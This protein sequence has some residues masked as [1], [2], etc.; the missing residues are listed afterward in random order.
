MNVAAALRLIR[1][2]FPWFAG[3]AF[4]SSVGAELILDA[5]GALGAPVLF[6]FL[7]VALCQIALL[8]R[9]LRAC[10][11]LALEKGRPLGA[12]A[13]SVLPLALLFALAA[14][15]GWA[16]QSAASPLPGTEEGLLCLAADGAIGFAFLVLGALACLWG[17]DRDKLTPQARCCME[18]VSPRMVSGKSWLR[19]L[20]I[21]SCNPLDC[22]L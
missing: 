2:A 6:A 18:I 10:G 16:V 19:S 5:G 20:R 1:P 8:A 14:L 11:S 9:A 4:V 17:Q 13:K 12:P 3:V 15:L 22:L 21:C 7:S